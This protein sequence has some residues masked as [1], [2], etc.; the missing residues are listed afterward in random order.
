MRSARG[1]VTLTGAVEG[2]P[3]SVIATGMGAP[4]MDF[5]CREALATLPRD[6]GALLVRFGTCGAVRDDVREG[7]VIVATGS[8]LVRRGPDAFGAGAGAGAAGAPPPPYSTCAPVAA[9]PAL[10]DALAR[11]S[12]RRS[13]RRPS[14][15]RAQ[16]VGVLVLLEPGPRGRAPDDRNDGAVEALRAQRTRLREHGDGDLPP[17]RPR[18]LRAP[19]GRGARGRACAIAVAHRPSGAVASAEA[20]A[21]LEALGGAAVLR[22][23]AGDAARQRRRAR[24]PPLPP[25]AAPSAAAPPTAPAEPF[26][27]ATAARL[28]A[29]EWSE[30]VAGADLS[31][32]IERAFAY[33]GLG[34]LVV[35]GVPGVA[36]RRAAL[37]PLGA[38]F[39]ALPPATR[40]KYEH[41]RRTA[42]GWSPA[43]EKLEGRPDHAKG[44]YY[45]NPI[46]ARAVRR[47]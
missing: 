35:R 28:V 20:V 26:A 24:A 34:I 44:S 16:R 47:G 13:A 37:L 2:V 22:A 29:L 10:A 15:A 46:H 32:H 41:A 39:A 9:D 25:P 36:E 1:F 43:A 30:L 5:M 7:T 19:G 40:A 21:R 3:V 27:E 33:E 8:T 12:A 18:A 38:R 31:A 42:H 11:S 45:N 14:R 23:L 4:M 6:A 17:L